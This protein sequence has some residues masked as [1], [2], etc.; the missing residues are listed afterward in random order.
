MQLKRGSY[1]HRRLF[2]NCV[3]SDK[4]QSYYDLPLMKA[5]SFYFPLL[6][7]AALL[8]AAILLCPK[9]IGTWNAAR[10]SFC[11][12]PNA[13]RNAATMLPRRSIC[14]SQPL[15]NAANININKPQQMQAQAQTQVVEGGKKRARDAQEEVLMVFSLLTNAF[16]GERERNYLYLTSHFVIMAILVKKE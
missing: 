5:F 4:V 13:C 14:C 7:S 11:L 9:H 12:P 8:L 1:S 10:F 15:R 2:R 3:C 6:C 16:I